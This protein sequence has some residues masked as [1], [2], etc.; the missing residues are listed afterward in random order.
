MREETKTGEAGKNKR[1]SREEGK[2]EGK[3]KGGRG[4][5]GEEERKRRDRMEYLFVSND[6]SIVVK[7]VHVG[8]LHLVSGL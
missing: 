1:R 2:G 4:E 6:F 3:E 7:Q 5:E 8:L